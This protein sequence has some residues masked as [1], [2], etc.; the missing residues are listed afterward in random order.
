[1]NP[2]TPTLTPVSPA[3]SAFIYASTISFVLYRPNLFS[4]SR[5]TIGN[6][7]N[8]V[9]RVLSRQAVQMEIQRVQPG[10]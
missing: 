10:P 5:R 6:V 3:A 4:S 7:S 1:M 8:H 2:Y 9:A